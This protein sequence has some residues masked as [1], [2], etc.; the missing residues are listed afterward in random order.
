VTIEENVLMGGFGSAVMELL[1]DL[2]INIPVY[3]MGLPDQFIE[4]GGQDILREKY[5]LDREG[6]YKNVKKIFLKYATKRKIRQIAF[7]KR[8]GAES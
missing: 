4:H 7:R 2:D 3:R 1:R 6:I 5:G 8:L